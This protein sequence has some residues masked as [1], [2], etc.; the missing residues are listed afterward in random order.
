MPVRLVKQSAARKKFSSAAA[1]RALW[2]G[3]T[4][5]R[6]SRATERNTK[7]MQDD[8]A[9]RREADE[10]VRLYGELV[11][12]L[13]NRGIRGVD[14]LVAMHQQVRAAVDTIAGQEIDAALLQIA[15]LL[16]RLRLIARALATLSEM[17]QALGITVDGEEFAEDE[18]PTVGAGTS[19][20]RFDSTRGH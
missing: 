12:R 6:P 16:D 13:S 8:E 17:R 14:E 4:V 15:T 1:A 9:F 2:T 5:S 19:P 7:S 20:Y 3:A 10:L 11:R 18:E